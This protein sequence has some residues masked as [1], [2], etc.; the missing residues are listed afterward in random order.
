MEN[1]F[2]NEMEVK[3][4]GETILLRPT[5][6]NLAAMENAMGGVAYLAWRFGKGIDLESRTVNAEA[7][8]KAM[9]TMSETAQ[10]IYF[11]QAEKKFTLEEV[12]QL[13]L[14]EGVRVCTVVVPFLVRVCAGNKLQAEPSERQK[15][16]SPESNQ[17]EN[18]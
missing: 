9:P 14:D 2:R 18:Q 12:M 16:S 1:K 11:N 8:A 10:I 13:C 6:E 17:V 7:S 15:K 3:V 5:F 4:G